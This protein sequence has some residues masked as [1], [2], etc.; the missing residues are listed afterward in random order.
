MEHHNGR[1]SRGRYLLRIDEAWFPAER[2]RSMAIMQSTN[3]ALYARCRGERRRIDVG[4]GPAETS[5]LHSSLPL[6]LVSF[7]FSRYERSFA[8]RLCR[9]A[10]RVGGRWAM[11]WMGWKD[12]TSMYSLAMAG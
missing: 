4:K 5:W 11:P 3:S 2:R 12:I 9:E 6:L 1:E 10:A 7:F 8:A